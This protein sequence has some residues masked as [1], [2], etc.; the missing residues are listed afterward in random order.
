MAGPVFVYYQLH[1]FYQNHRLYANSLSTDQLK[2][3]S[4]SSSDA[5]DACS[6]I[7]YNRDLYVNV[8]ITGA[9]LDK[10][11][12]ANPCGMIAYTVFNDSFS[13]GG[14]VD[15]SHQGIAWPTDL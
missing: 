2:G 15:I 3:E 14:S 1:N 8:S 4:I 6:P 9:A 5:Q 13:L 11:A 12:L 7:V 10:D